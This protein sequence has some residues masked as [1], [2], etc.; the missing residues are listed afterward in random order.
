MN[1]ESANVRGTRQSN[2]VALRAKFLSKK[3]S[4]AFGTG[5]RRMAV[6][7]NTEV[8]CASGSEQN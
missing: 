1:R 4:R 8:G 7:L 5:N 6:P 3:R 2:G